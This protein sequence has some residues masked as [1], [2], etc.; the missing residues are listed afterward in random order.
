MKKTL[1]SVGL[2]KK[3]LLHWWCHRRRT[4]LCQWV[5]GRELG[6]Y[7]V[8]YLKLRGAGWL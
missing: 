6:W 7:S 8:G 4:A 5:E 2:R 1:E 3:M